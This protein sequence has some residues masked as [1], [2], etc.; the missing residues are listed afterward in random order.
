MVNLLDE[1]AALAQQ[2]VLYFRARSRLC[3]SV[4]SLVGTHRRGMLPRAVLGRSDGRTRVA[5]PAALVPTMK[6][7]SRGTLFRFGSV[8]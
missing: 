8:T 7:A 6:K 5:L 4:L 2:R 1:G 3:G